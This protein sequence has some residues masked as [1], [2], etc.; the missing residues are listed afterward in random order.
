MCVGLDLQMDESTTARTPQTV[1]VDNLFQAIGELT[2]SSA[3]QPFRNIVIAEHALHGAT[4]QSLDALRDI[5]PAIRLVLVHAGDRPSDPHIAAL[6]SKFDLLLR[7]P[8]RVD[9]L[10]QALRN[11]ASPRCEEQSAA[12]PSK[13]AEPTATPQQ[14]TR[15]QEAQRQSESRPRPPVVDIELSA[16][17]SKPP[18]PHRH[19][20]D[21]PLGDVDLVESILNQCGRLQELAL[22]LIAQQTGWT[23]VAM[24]TNQTPADGA[25]AI[26]TYESQMFGTLTSNIADARPL[27][28]W[29]DWL[30]RWLALDE[31]HRAH[32]LMALRDDLT[33]AWNRRFFND[34]LITSLQRARQLR[35]PVT[36][37]VFDIDDFKI[38]NDRY[39]H[40]AG[41]EILIETVRLLES[42]IRK[43]D[44]VCRIGGDEFAVIF[45]DLEGPRAAGSAHPDAV[46]DIATRF[47]KQVTAMTFPKLS[48]EAPG[49][50]T[51]SG[52]LSTF[53]W[54]GD[55]PNE[56]LRLAD[57]RALRSK[58]AG[59]NVITFGPE[60]DESL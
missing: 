10:D 42:V 43:C 56:L 36:V 41:D 53:P 39:G 5:D 24:H 45:A 21:E 19:S 26:I 31:S 59:K 44:R 32:R 3:R 7:A 29:A 57:H 25:T 28:P 48:R 60:A 13:P 12:P 49:S 51:I 40:D 37:M 27:K 20:R 2:T 30:A 23:D 15:A 16:S 4:A 58:R 52:G 35:V 8:V 11:G 54:D 47:Q 38:Y 6:A 9:D 14:P 1:R 22:R 46:G 34:F 18:A 17:E 50:L 55:D 33:G